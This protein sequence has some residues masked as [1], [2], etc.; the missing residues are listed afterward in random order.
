MGNLG[1]MGNAD[2]RLPITAPQGQLWGRRE[3]ERR[4]FCRLPTNRGEAGK[5]ASIFPPSPNKLTWRRESA[6]L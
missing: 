2:K 6:K 5:H 3:S 1:K 4:A